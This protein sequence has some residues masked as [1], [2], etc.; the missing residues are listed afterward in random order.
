MDRTP[1]VTVAV[2]KKHLM[3]FR[4]IKVVQDGR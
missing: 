4:N 2:D 3:T 1:L